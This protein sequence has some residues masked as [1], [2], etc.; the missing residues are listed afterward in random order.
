MFVVTTQSPPRVLAAVKVDWCKRQRESC[1]CFVEM[2]EDNIAHAA[3]WVLSKQQ[4][5][6]YWRSIV[7]SSLVVGLPTLFQIGIFDDPQ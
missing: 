4:I 7:Y 3:A 5:R 2:P 6:P 1:C